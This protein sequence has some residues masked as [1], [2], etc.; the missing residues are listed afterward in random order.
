MRFQQAVLTVAL[1]LTTSM[2]SAAVPTDDLEFVG[3][4]P[5]RVIDTRGNGFTGEFGPPLLSAG[6]PRNFTLAGHCGVPAN[7]QAVA[8]N[9]GV[10]LTGGAGFILIYPAG[11]TAPVVSSLN[12]ER[13]NQTIANAAVVPLGT[14]GAVTVVA[15]VASA[16]FFVDVNGYYLDSPKVDSLN[17]LTGALT[18]EAGA[19]V[20]VTPSGSTITIAS[21]GTTGPTGPTG[22]IGPAGATGPTGAGVAGPTGPT[23]ADG[24]TG[25]AGATGPTGPTGATGVAGATGA[26]GADG[27]TGPAGVAGPTGAAGATGATGADGATGPTGVAGPTGGTGPAGATGA[28]GPAGATGATG[29]A[30]ATGAT[31][32]AG[33]TGPTGAPGL[34]GAAGPTGATGATGATGPTGATGAAGVGAAVLNVR[35]LTLAAAATLNGLAAA[36]PDQVVLVNPTT[37]VAQTLTLPAVAGNSGQLI[38][39]RNISAA[40]DF[41]LAGASGGT[42]NIGAS[43]AGLPAS[44]SLV[45]VICDGTTWFV[46][47]QH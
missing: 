36:T 12:Y 7:A 14:A 8:L 22:P 46:I 40:N 25:P 3:V 24:A 28:T 20:T 19:N 1:G 23:G 31:G 10:T 45:S 44:G 37:A 6:V 34:T 42:L 32:V 5:C 17:G 39:I 41:N 29:V 30:G 33:P 26:T 9:L 13:A 11:G 16:E 21:V 38:H 2:A 35:T 18:L 27:A 15:G 43:A 4:A 47:N